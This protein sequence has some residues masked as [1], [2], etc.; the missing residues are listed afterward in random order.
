MMVPHDVGQLVSH[1]WY[2][3]TAVEGREFYS[4][5]TEGDGNSVVCQES[6]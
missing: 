1:L 5:N 6:C 3:D 4:Y 2:V